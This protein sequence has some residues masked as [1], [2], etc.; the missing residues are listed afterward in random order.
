[1]A[2]CFLWHLLLQQ[3]FVN[4]DI[5]WLAATSQSYPSLKQLL[6]TVWVYGLARV[7]VRIMYG[8]H[9]HFSPL[10]LKTQ[11]WHARRLPLEQFYVG[12][13]T[14][15]IAN[16][17][18]INLTELW[19]VNLLRQRQTWPQL[20]RELSSSSATATFPCPTLSVSELAWWHHQHQVS[21]AWVEELICVLIRKDVRVFPAAEEASEQQKRCP[22]RDEGGLFQGG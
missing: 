1:M 18:A 16:T 13:L 10:S 14:Q 2:A 11:Q 5:Y 20:W 22:E 12:S 9:Y 7:R 6:L 17:N 4:D 8:M 3:K 21:L 19:T 15:Q